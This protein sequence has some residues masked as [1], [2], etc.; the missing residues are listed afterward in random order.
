MTSRRW[1]DE[2]PNSRRLTDAE[3]PLIEDQD[4]G[5]RKQSSTLLT[6]C[7]FILGESRCYAAQRALFT[8]LHDILEPIDVPQHTVL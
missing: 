1:E 3:E 5:S 8:T 4:G 6:V 2:E 7:P